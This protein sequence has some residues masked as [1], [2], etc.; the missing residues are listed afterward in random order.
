MISR[1]YRLL[2]VPRLQL[3]WT[4]GRRL[5]QALVRM[6][7]D[8]SYTGREDRVFNPKHVADRSVKNGLVHEVAFGGTSRK[9][10]FQSLGTGS[11]GSDIDNQLS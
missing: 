6:G 8:S 9:S 3:Q 1:E 11:G 10:V 2:K 4:A 5:L 7:H